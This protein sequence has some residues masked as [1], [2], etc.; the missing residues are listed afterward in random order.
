MTTDNP[1]TN[2]AP[3]DKAAWLRTLA[4]LFP[5]VSGTEAR[6]QA[7]Q[8]IYPAEYQWQHR[9]FVAAQ[10]ICLPLWQAL[11]P[12]Y[13]ATLAQT[14]GDDATPL[15]VRVVHWPETVAEHQQAL[16]R[17]LAES[18]LRDGW[19][20][21]ARWFDEVHCRLNDPR[22]KQAAEQAFR[23]T[24]VPLREIPLYQSF[25]RASCQQLV[26]LPV[27]QWHALHQRTPDSPSDYCPQD[28]DAATVDRL[29]TRMAQ[30][31][32]S[33]PLVDVALLQDNPS[34]HEP[35]VWP[36][37]AGQLTGKIDC[38]GMHDRCEHSWRGETEPLPPDAAYSEWRYE[39]FY[40]QLQVTLETGAEWLVTVLAPQH[41]VRRL[42]HSV[43]WFRRKSS[44]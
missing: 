26:C 5:D 15:A 6:L 36:T 38:H 35:V 17:L 37:N 18:R 30:V 41:F 25:I 20:T 39:G 10:T 3:T 32:N 27:D 29:A 9:H 2:P 43:A 7:L 42:A 31:F 4:P 11:A 22:Q 19:H 40:G 34:W 23:Q 21:Y 1:H 33:P 28:V 44:L 8:P 24:S 16:H 13:V 12:A 14:F